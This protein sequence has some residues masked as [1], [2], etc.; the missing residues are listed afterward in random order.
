ME[1][2]SLAQLCLAVADRGGGEAL[3][4]GRV[5]LGFAELAAAAT[6]A[7]GRL[8]ERGVRPGD[9]VALQAPNST[10]WVVA[11]FG[12]LLAGGTLLP[13]G[14]RVP[15]AERDRL[16]ARL[17][18]RLVIDPDLL[19]E[20]TAPPASG[21]PVD[22]PEVDPDAVAVLM[23]SSGTT[24]E[25]KA[26]AMT[27]RQLLRVYREVARRLGVGPG[28]RLLGLVPLS[29]SFGFNGVL[30][31]AML[32]GS[33]VRLLA[34][35]DR[36][37][38]PGLVVAERVNVLTGPPTLLRDLAGSADL[39]RGRV[40]LV[41]AGGAEV[42]A[43]ELHE[44]GR[45]LGGP[46]LVVGYGMSETCGTV[47]LAD[48]EP[49]APADTRVWM[50]PIEDT[51][52]RIADPAAAGGVGRVLVRGPSVVGRLDVP[53]AAGEWLDTG[54]LGLLDG[55]G[56]LAVVGRGDDR[57]VVA[58]FTVS[59]AAVEQALLRHPSVA[60]ALV[61]G[62]PD[63]RR[64][65]RLVACVVPAGDEPLAVPLDRAGLD[66]HLRA[67]LAPYELPSEY[68]AMAALPMTHSGKASRAEARKWLD[69]P[70]D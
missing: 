3:Y 64:G 6:T 10:A 31:V 16:L 23:T 47:A 42:S 38:L 68:V 37:T 63:E 61:L 62:V 65:Q 56:R 26:V 59:P 29:H 25:P 21:A 35:Y 15:P 51:E 8:L 49:P 41:V 70:R 50:R 22:L 34:S 20:L 48:D 5:R 57:V 52:V 58:G 11:A 36:A 12:V 44:I 24:G 54:D 40:D 18:P 28:D 66:A 19:A 39:L 33:S 9:R 55:R 45:E 53:V 13:V 1:A 7:A 32:A 46:R 60:A 14:H 69:S 30:L 2:R 43:G 67:R 4:D 27:H 17:P